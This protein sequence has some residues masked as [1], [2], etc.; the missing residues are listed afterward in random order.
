MGYTA[1]LAGLVLSGGAAVLLVILPLVGKLT[2]KYPAKYLVAVGWLGISMAMFVSTRATDLQMSFSA[3]AILRIYQ[4]LPIAFVFIPITL[5][6]YVGLPAEKSNSAA[7]LVNFM[8]NMGGSVGT[9]IVATVVARRSQFHQSILAQH[10][11]SPRFMGAAN[12]M[13]LHLNHAGIGYHDAHKSAIAGLTR[14]IQA[15]AAVLSYID[16]YWILAVATA[17]MFVLSFWLK[18]NKPGEGGR[19]PVH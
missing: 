12:G 14:M 7:G 10:T 18:K 15:Q 2:N 11:R 8:R 4:N 19:V 13:A 5:A 9:S 16:L 3:C 1:E 6:A 17:V